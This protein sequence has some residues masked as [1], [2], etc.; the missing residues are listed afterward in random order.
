MREVGLDPRDPRVGHSLRMAEDMRGMPRHVSI[1]SGRVRDRGWALVDLC[2]IEAA[3]MAGRT[4]IQWD[5]DDIDTAC[6]S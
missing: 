2:P 6:V 5:K 3:T 4:V 1:H